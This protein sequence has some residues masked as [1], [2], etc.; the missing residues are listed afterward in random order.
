MVSAQFVRL[1]PHDFQ[2]GIYL[3][4]EIMGCGDGT[5]LFFLL[6]I[7]IQVTST[8]KVCF[9]SL[10]LSSQAFRWV[11]TPKAPYPV[12]PTGGCSEKEFQCQNGRCVVAGP[13]GVVCDGVNDCG[14]GTDEMHCGKLFLLLLRDIPVFI[15][16]LW[17]FFKQ[18]TQPSPT[19]SPRRCPVGQ[20]SCP[21][22]IC[23]DAAKRCDGISH[24]PRGEDEIGCHPHDITTQSDRS[25]AQFN[26]KNKT[27]AKFWIVVGWDWE[28]HFCMC[29]SD[30]THRPQL[31]S[32]LLQRLLSLML[33]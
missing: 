11:T 7:F 4:L 1:L 16:F 19:A 31:L 32:E 30:H 14:D 22:G 21:P 2:N 17:P 3:R 10:W 20:F 9:I 23:I 15:C 6:L 27:M 26:D 29:S 18:G 28:C 5:H 13:E 24:C 12:S 33:L 25:G 8:Q